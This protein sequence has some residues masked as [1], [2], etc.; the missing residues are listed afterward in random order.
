MRDVLMSPDSDGPEVYYY[1]IRGGKEKRNVTIWESGVVGSEYIKTFG[2]YHVQNFSETY[3]VLAGEGL[4]LLQDVPV[5]GAV[6]WVKAIYVK[7]GDRVRIP[8]RAGH[9]G[10]N[11]GKSWLVTMDDSP[12]NLSGDQSAW[13]KHADYESVR[14]LRG[15]AYYV[16]EK[17]GQPIFV[18]NPNYKNHPDV[19]IEKA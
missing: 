7:P 19:V 10:V 12:V 18:K 5:D 15:F 2:H 3:E 14:G 9:L 8:E 13:P 17:D 1:M 4:I 6:G 16:V 11:L